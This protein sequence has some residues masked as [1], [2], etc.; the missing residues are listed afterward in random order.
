[1][2]THATNMSLSAK[3][4]YLARIHARYQRVGRAF[5]RASS[6]SFVST[7]A[8]TA[9]PRCGCCSDPNPEL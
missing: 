5:S 1:M 8:T 7:A 6:T 2:V 9:K 3:R 4:E